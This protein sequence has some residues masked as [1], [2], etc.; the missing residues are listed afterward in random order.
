V[1]SASDLLNRRRGRRLGSRG[2]QNQRPRGATIEGIRKVRIAK[3][4]PTSKAQVDLAISPAAAVLRVVNDLPVRVPDVAQARDGRG[5]PGMR[6][7]V[8][9][10]GGVIDAGRCAQGWS[11]RAEI[12]LSDSSQRFWRCPR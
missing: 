9:L 6:Q 2:H 8:E 1:S 12:P 11:V 10:L 5:L 7:R 3:H 4:A